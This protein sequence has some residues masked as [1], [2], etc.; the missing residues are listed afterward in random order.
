M[1]IRGGALFVYVGICAGVAGEKCLGL[2]ARLYFHL[3]VA[4]GASAG[5]ALAL[6]TGECG[7][8]NVE[9]FSSIDFSFVYLFYILG[10][11]FF[12]FFI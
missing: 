7:K 5:V 2:R 1:D 4:A 10:F 8:L 6:G 11:F 9:R 3:L 12:F